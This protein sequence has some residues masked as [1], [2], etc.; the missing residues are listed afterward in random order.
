MKRLI[1]LMIS[2]LMT[3]SVATA[4]G[5]ETTVDADDQ[6]DYEQTV[7]PLEGNERPDNIDLCEECFGV[8]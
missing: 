4:C 3:V 7:K 2:M 6:K 5:N 8:E 1:V